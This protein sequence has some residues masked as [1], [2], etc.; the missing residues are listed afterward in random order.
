LGTPLS[1]AL[2]SYGDTYGVGIDTDP[3]AIPDPELLSH[4]LTAAVDELEH[5]VRPR[6]AGRVARPT[7]LH[8][9]APAASRPRP[10]RRRAAA[11]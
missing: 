4:Y 7:V 5:R 11:S 8:R 2:L 3:A 9:R 6:S 1:I 10:R